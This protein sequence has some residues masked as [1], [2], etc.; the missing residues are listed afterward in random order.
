MQRR[1]FGA[2]LTACLLVAGAFTAPSA[3]ADKVGDLQAQVAR[4]EATSEALNEESEK[5]AEKQNAVQAELDALTA[6]VG[7]VETKLLAQGDAIVALNG[8]L[9]QFAVS[10]YKY[11]DLT[12]GLATV[13]GSVGNE[14][15]Q[16][17][18]YSSVILGGATDVTD[19]MRAVRD[20]T[21]K[22]QRDLLAKQAKQQKLTAS[23]AKSQAVLDKKKVQ[24]DAL[25]KGASAE[26][27][28]AIVERQR[29]RERAEALAFQA[30]QKALA[31][32][33]A[34]DNA[35]RSLAQPKAAAAPAAGAPARP[36]VG[37]APAAAALPA[38]VPAKPKAKERPVPPPPPA[39]SGAAGR[40]VAAAYSQLGV[41]YGFAT[42]KPGES[43]DCSG[44]TQWS[45]SQA[46]VGIPRVSSAQWN[47]L[48]HVPLDQ[49]QPGD[50]IFYY[51]DVHHVAIYVGNGTVIHAP[52]SGSTVSLAPLR[53]QVIGAARPG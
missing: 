38:A 17:D 26:L 34:A 37:N 7:V 13:F 3:S 14:A 39:V 48:P 21:G 27:K 43:F 32:K 25:Q 41:P 52:F 50:L 9:S 16:R 2:A 20:D 53:G 6:E 12:S 31:D 24:I 42:A 4:Y 47:G 51:N 44:L 1:V 10:T 5:L 19:Q 8:K 22:L 36:A 28:V 30:R 46:G 15:G 23:I 29:A 35:R 40:A 33:A 18:G 45:W 49:I 11:G